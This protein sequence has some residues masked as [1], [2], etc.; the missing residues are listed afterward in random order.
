[1]ITIELENEHLRSGMACRGQARLCFD[2]PLPR[3]R[4]VATLRASQV[5][6]SPLARES[7]SRRILYE[8]TVEIDGAA[9]D[10]ESE[11]RFELQVPSANELERYPEPPEFLKRLLLWI[12][13]NAFEPI[14]WSLDIRIERRWKKDLLAS[15][16][17]TVTLAEAPRQ[18][19]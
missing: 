7:S 10:R 6:R 13:P 14:S 1:M 15:R 16:A 4:V 12:A 8:G 19:S 17:I 11:L 2:E 5:V 18:A 3:T 9:Q